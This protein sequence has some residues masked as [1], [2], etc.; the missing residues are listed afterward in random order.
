MVRIVFK[1]FAGALAISFAAGAAAQSWKDSAAVRALYENAKKERKVIIWGPQQREVDWIPEAFGSMFPGIE[2]QWLGDNN[3]ATKAIAEARAGRHEVDVFH[4]SL[5]GV[6][7][8]N[9]R[10]LLAV[11]DWSVFGTKGRNVALDGKAGLTSNH[12]YA[13]VYN[14]QKVKPSDLPKLWTDLLDPRYKGKMVGSSFLMPRL[15]GFLGLEWGEDKALQFA[16]NLV[17]KTDILVTQAPRDSFLQSGER[18]YAIGDFDSAG[19]FWASR[20]LPVSYVI[21]QPAVAVQ[22][23]IAVMANA[24]NRNAARLLAGW[25]TTPEAKRAREKMRF[26]ADYGPDSE[27]P[28]AKKLHSSGVKFLFENEANMAQREQIYKKATPIFTGQK[29]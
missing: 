1:L 13:V 6:L 23:I 29:R 24:P 18:V 15:M 3:I 19:L 9:Q 28:A 21:P 17:E 26:E 22:F 12:V 25:M 7:P 10:G 5:G 27:S 16:R 4:T 11:N 20:G 2:V 8:L 14:T